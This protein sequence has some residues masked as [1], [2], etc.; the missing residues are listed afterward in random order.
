MKSA[1]RS[2]V[3]FFVILGTA[4]PSFLSANMISTVAGDGT[5]GFSGDGGPAV[6]AQLAWP[7]EVEFDAA[8]NM[9]ICDTWGNNRVR[10]VDAVTGIITTIAGTGTKGYNGDGIL[11]TAAD[12]A[13]PRIHD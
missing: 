5:Q 4:C 12:R 1:G 3:V 13:T 11:A 7:Y 10:R 8:G 6:L 9:V 2:L